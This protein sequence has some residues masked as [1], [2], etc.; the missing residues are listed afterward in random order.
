[1]TCDITSFYCPFTVEKI[2]AYISFDEII[3]SFKSI[4]PQACKFK[5]K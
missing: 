2:Q 1:M 3:N 4:G 5:L